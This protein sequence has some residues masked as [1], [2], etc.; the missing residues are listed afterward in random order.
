MLKKYRSAL[1]AIALLSVI[2]F[3]ITLVAAAVYVLFTG[4]NVF[5][6]LS[7]GLFISGVIVLIFGTF[8]E[9]FK[10]NGL[11]RRLDEWFSKMPLFSG[12]GPDT[13]RA[14]NIASDTASI[15][16]TD[17]RHFGFSFSVAFIFTG[18]ILIIISLAILLVFYK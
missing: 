2:C 11:N 8:V 10:L 7:N 3:M 18:L 15:E 1:L 13:A 5:I 17:D 6:S 4:G 16:K 9:Y 14:N 12:I